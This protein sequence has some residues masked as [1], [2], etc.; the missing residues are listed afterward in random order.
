MKN[1]LTLP[2]R[3]VS[4]RSLFWAGFGTK[5][6]TIAVNG[7]LQ[8]LDVI[9]IHIIF[10]ATFVVVDND[11]LPHVIGYMLLVVRLLGSDAGIG[12]HNQSQN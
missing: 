12:D 4:N 10:S 6:R 2:L 7:N 3:H 8:R 9:S 11:V 1:Q 5:R